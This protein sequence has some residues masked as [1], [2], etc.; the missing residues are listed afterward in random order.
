MCWTMAKRRRTKSPKGTTEK[1]SLSAGMR[2]LIS[3]STVE[4]RRKQQTDGPADEQRRRTDD[5][6][7]R[8]ED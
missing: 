3:R 1:E 5:P 7:E 6:A 8:R 2:E 4:E